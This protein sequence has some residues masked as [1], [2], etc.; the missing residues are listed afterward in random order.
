MKAIIKVL[1]IF[2]ILII[3]LFVIGIIAALSFSDTREIM[4]ESYNS[5]KDSSEITIE[6]IEDTFNAEEDS[7]SVYARDDGTFQCEDGKIVDDP[8]YCLGIEEELKEI[9]EETY[10]PKCNTSWKCDSWSECSKSGLQTRTC[11]DKND[12]GTT[13]GKPDTS[14]SCTYYYGL[15]DEV[16]IDDISYTLHSKTESSTAGDSSYY[17]FVGEEADGIFY[18]FDMTIENVGKETKTF[19]GENI[20]IEDS[21]GR[22]YDHDSMAEIWV[23]DSF[24]YAQ[25][26]PGLPKRGKI[27]FDIPAGLE[28]NIKISSTEVFSYDIEYISWK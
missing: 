3:F 19:W 9:I 18:I 17:G 8:T 13:E 27:V 16:I 24:Q 26:Q 12:C 28:G 10:I 21:Q 11:T 4:G 15:G 14:E 5:M 2:C 1:G 20:K 25:L 23:D 6:G 22:T 7:I